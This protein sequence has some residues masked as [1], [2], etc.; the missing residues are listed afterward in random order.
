MTPAPAS[1]ETAD[2][3]ANLTFNR[4]VQVPGAILTAG[5]YRFRLAD[6]DSS[7]NIVQVLSHDGSA[8]YAMFFTM[9]GYRAEAVDDTMVTFKETA[10][11]VPPIIDTLFYGGEHR[12]YTFLYVGEKPIMTA[13]FAPQ[14][15]ITYTYTPTAVTRPAPAAEPMP[16]AAATPAAVEPTATVAGEPPVV[17][18][19]TPAAAP[20]ELPKTATPLPLVAL[21]GLWSLA[22]G[23]GA[24]LIRRRDV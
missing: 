4:P 10:A 11:G 20:E 22:L 21:G 7:R 5:T 13:P 19:E 1:A 2:K 8:V 18:E 6:P 16:A 24:A 15:P 9:H 17:S 23:L 14:P 12:G 3:L